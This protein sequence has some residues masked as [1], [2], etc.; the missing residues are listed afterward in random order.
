MPYI[1][2]HEKKLIKFWPILVIHYV[3]SRFVFIARG[4]QLDNGVDPVPIDHLLS[5]KEKEKKEYHLRTIYFTKDTLLPFCAMYKQ[6]VILSQYLQNWTHVLHDM[7]A[8][9]VLKNGNLITAHVR[10]VGSWCGFNVARLLPF[11]WRS[12]DGQAGVW[13][14][15][16][17]LAFYHFRAG[18]LGGQAGW[19]PLPGC[20]NCPSSLPPS[21]IHFLFC[22]HDHRISLLLSEWIYSSLLRS[23][24][25]YPISIS[26]ASYLAAVSILHGVC[27]LFVGLYMFSS[28]PLS[29]FFTCSFY[30]FWWECKRTVTTLP[31][32]PAE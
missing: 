27:P 3:I 28:L 30:M 10:P 22:S 17:W 6:K 1:S 19:L 18:L 20:I 29:L 11:L 2:T 24:L 31:S 9:F 23:E 5:Q 14:I 8:N 15:S 13:M 25:K 26:L 4:V 16:M 12:V 21:L 32:F 7:W